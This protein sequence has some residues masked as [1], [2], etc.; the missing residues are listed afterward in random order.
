MTAALASAVGLAYGLWALWWWT[1][2]PPAASLAGFATFSFGCTLVLA[3]AYGLAAHLPPVSF[4]PSRRESLGALCLVGAYFLIVAVP[5][6]P[7]ALAILPPL[8][9]VLWA[10]LRRN[11]RCEARPDLLTRFATQPPPR[12]ADLLLLGCLPLTATIVYAL[13]GILGARPMTGWVLYALTV[14]AGFGL[15]IGSVLA[16]LRKKPLPLHAQPTST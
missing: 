1:E 7:V 6:R 12:L 4:H 8:A 2:E 11:A 14:P 5:S 16:I 10:A 13:A 15:F 3:I 9:L